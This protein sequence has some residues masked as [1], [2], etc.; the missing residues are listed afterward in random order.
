MRAMKNPQVSE[1]NSWRFRIYGPSNSRT[2]LHFWSC[3]SPC[4]FSKDFG[5]PT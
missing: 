5:S 4:S 1:Q 3:G 2:T